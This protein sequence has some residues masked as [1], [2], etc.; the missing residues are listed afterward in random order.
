MARLQPHAH[1]QS[2]T[3]GAATLS[4][5]PASQSANI[6]DFDIPDSETQDVA[7]PESEEC[8]PE[9]LTWRAVLPA[10]SLLLVAAGVFAYLLWQLCVSTQHSPNPHFAFSPLN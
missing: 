3:A 8:P 10:L 7:A 1:N 6:Q 2:E 5:Y 4:R 9:P